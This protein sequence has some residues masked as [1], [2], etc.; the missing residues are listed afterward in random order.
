[1]KSKRPA[2]EYCWTSC[3]HNLVK[4]PEPE[5]QEQVQRQV[6]ALNLVVS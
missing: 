6:P 3:F 4:I 1:M 5:S 2:G